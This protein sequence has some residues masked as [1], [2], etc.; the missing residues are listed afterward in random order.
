MKAGPY[1]LVTHNTSNCITKE[2]P[3]F[4]T[5]FTVSSEKNGVR[6]TVVNKKE[7][8]NVKFRIQIYYID[9]GKI[10][11]FEIKNQNCQ[12]MIIKIVLKAL[13]ITY[14]DQKCT[15]K[16]LTTEIRNLN[17]DAV[18]HSVV[19]KISYGS[20]QIRWEIAV[21]EAKIMCLDIH[22]EI[23]DDKRIDNKETE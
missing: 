19:Q 12:N 7:I 11:V 9:Q 15:M 8:K 10:K 3:W 1:K 6:G 21:P 2:Q 5:N 20:V 18:I 17:L 23:I 14:N 4:H 16:P 13:G 22:L